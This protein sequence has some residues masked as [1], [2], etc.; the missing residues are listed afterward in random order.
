MKAQALP[1]QRCGD[2][3]EHVGATPSY[4]GQG[5]VGTEAVTESGRKA[6][7]EGTKGGQESNHTEMEASS[8]G[9]T[10]VTERYKGTNA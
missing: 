8:T 2:G 3:N 10:R 9:S 1:A 6:S 7:G 4:L 5:R